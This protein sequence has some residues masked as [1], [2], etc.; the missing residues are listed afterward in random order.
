MLHKGKACILLTN[1]PR[2]GDA[3]W[4][5][6]LKHNLLSVSQLNNIGFYKVEFMNE[7]AKLLDEKGNLVGYG[8]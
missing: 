7:R 1:E 6:G 8:K 3:Y 5:E 4:V 2:Y